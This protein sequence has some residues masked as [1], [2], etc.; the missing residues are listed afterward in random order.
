MHKNVSSVAK[1][2]TSWCL[3]LK[4]NR[5]EGFLTEDKNWEEFLG[6]L[7]IGHLDLYPY[8][9]GR[10]IYGEGTIIV[11]ITATFGNL[12]LWDAEIEL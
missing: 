6:D 7:T 4:Q 8:C 10:R 3:V 12:S 1:D 5:D 9:D 11:A 2:V